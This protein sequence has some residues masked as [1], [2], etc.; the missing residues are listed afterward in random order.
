MASKKRGLGPA[1]G[2]LR[3]RM[4]ELE[5]TDQRSQGKVDPATGSR[6]PPSRFYPR[7]ANAL[8]PSGA[9]FEVYWV[10][11]TDQYYQ[12]PGLSTCVVAHVFVP[13][14]ARDE[15]TENMQTSGGKTYEES[16]EEGMETLGQQFKEVSSTRLDRSQLGADYNILGYTYV[17]FRNRAGVTSGVYKYGPMPLHVYRSYREFTS[18]GQGVRRI[19]EPFGYTKS[20]WPV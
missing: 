16:M 5:T 15:L 11:P 18:K 10:S 12:G 2:D 14:L 20:S 13:T 1:I 4:Q 7:G 19:L 3:S 8:I 17:M 9:D 6:L